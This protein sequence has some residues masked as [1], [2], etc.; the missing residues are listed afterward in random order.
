MFLK[1]YLLCFQVFLNVFM[2]VISLI[3]VGSE[4][5]LNSSLAHLVTVSQNVFNAHSLQHQAFL[6]HFTLLTSKLQFQLTSSLQPSL[7]NPMLAHLLP[8]PDLALNCAG[9]ATCI[10][11]HSLNMVAPGNMTSE[12]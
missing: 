9:F 3:I 2:F 7:S 8:C 10:L 1:Q 4:N 12:M 11:S 6:S 5:E